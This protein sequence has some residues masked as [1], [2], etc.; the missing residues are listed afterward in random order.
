M[1]VQRQYLTHVTDRQMGHFRQA[2]AVEV[3]PG[4]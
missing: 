4:T 2:P 1:Q 3:T